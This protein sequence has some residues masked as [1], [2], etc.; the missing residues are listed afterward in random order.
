MENGEWPCPSATQS[1]TRPSRTDAAECTSMDG[2]CD[3]RG[4]SWEPPCFVYSD[5]RRRGE[6][7]ERRP[8]GIPKRSTYKTSDGFLSQADFLLRVLGAQR[9]QYSQW[10]RLPN[11]D[12]PAGIA[13]CRSRSRLTTSPSS[14][15]VQYLSEV[16]P[17][18]LVDPDPEMIAFA[19]EI[20][21]PPVA[22]RKP[23]R[24]PTVVKSGHRLPRQKQKRPEGRSW[25]NQDHD[26][27]AVSH[28]PSR[29][30]G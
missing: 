12:R 13:P 3:D 10:C 1:T 19:A 5:G 18:G 15:A 17:R 24:R 9:T 7:G 8:A 6:A 26:R 23:A 16:C 30:S 22:T 4:G 27:A 29:V 21:P 20:F 2:V 14:R 28:S 11:V 25:Y